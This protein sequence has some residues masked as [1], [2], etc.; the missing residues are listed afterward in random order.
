MNAAHQ[1]HNHDRTTQ[2]DEVAAYYFTYIDQAL[3]ASH[4]GM[5]RS[6]F[7]A[8]FKHVIGQSPLDYLTQWRMHRAGLL[9][10]RKGSNIAQIARVVGYKSESAF[11]KVFKRTIGTT[12]SDYIGRAFHSPSSPESVLPIGDSDH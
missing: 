5:S 1:N 10:R 8:R 7:A 2:P 11:T 6:G 12:P 4:A 3:G 9:M